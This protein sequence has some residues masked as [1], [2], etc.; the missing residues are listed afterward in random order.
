MITKVIG[1]GLA[2]FLM[3]VGAAAQTSGIQIFK[4][5]NMGTTSQWMKLGTF[6]AS[7][8]G[9]DVDVKIVTSNGFNANIAQDQVS[10][11][12]FKS[13]NANSVDANGFAGDSWWYQTGP[14]VNAPSQ[15]VWVANAAGTAATSFTLFAYFG[16]WNGDGSYYVVDAPP[17]TT[18]TNSAIGAQ[19]NP[20]SGSSTVL[21]AQ[22]QF[23]VGSNSSFA[24]NVGIGIS[25]PAYKLDVN[26]AIHS[27][28]GIVFPDGTTQTSALSS[29][30]QILATTNSSAPGINV[31]LNATSIPVINFTRW[32][33]SGNIQHNA[34]VG[35][36]FNPNTSEYDFAIGTGISTT[37]DQ[38]ATTNALVMTLAGNVGI[39][40]TASNA[41]LEV[42]GNIKLTAGTG[43]SMT[44][45]DGTV[46]STAWTGVL[47]G[48]DYAESVDVTGVR[49]EYLPGDVLVIDPEH[50]DRFRKASEPYSHMVAGIY[51]TKPG[52]TG[53]RQNS[54]KS[55]DELPMA[56]IGIVPTNVSTENGAILPGDLLVASSTAGYAMKGT[57][58]EK[59]TGAIIGKAMGHIEHGRGVIEVLVT[60][61]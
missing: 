61:Q 16:A 42:N 55:P 45:T 18:W 44:Y 1:S 19:T 60:L 56:M 29:G 15:V 54:M 27:S 50:P 59:L 49:T 25:A 37:G 32:T 17:G 21:V 51:S 8:Q 4:L 7:Q 41:K 48:G 2:V 35:Q 3:T 46:Q 39:G 13:S 34:S 14:T 43:S 6:N 22:N 36:F 33:G 30:G 53:R 20:G 31:T 40:T 26:G 5:P 38:T 10:H 52:V 24:G 58:K 28:A 47:T 11:I 12:H 23:Y 9:Y 57:D